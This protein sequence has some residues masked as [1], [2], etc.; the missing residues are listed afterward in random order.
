MS[1]SIYSNGM[2]IFENLINLSKI[3]PFYQDYGLWVVY[4]VGLSFLSWVIR[5]SGRNLSCSRKLY[6]YT[7]LK[8]HGLF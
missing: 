6:N 2:S 5:S 3:K 1:E 7:K 4:D 8:V